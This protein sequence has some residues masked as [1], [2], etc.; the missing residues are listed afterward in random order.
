MK[1]IEELLRIYQSKLE[2]KEAQIQQLRAI[3][4]DTQAH[5]IV[6]KYYLE[7]GMYE[8]AK[9]YLN[10]ISNMT[11]Q[12][13]Y[14][15]KLDTGNGLVN[16][17]LEEYLQRNVEIEFLCKGSF[18]NHMC[19]SE[20]D[21]CILCS[22]LFSN[23]I[24]AVD[25]LCKMPKIIRLE[26]KEE[27][28][29]FLIILENYIEWEIDIQRLGNGTSKQDKENHGYG[30]KNIKGIVEKYHGETKFL[31]EENIFSVEIKLPIIENV[32]L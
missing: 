31:V 9:A 21:I 23:A 5:C 25:K 12:H 7:S 26:L 16:A 13:S 18:L 28:K 1:N 20:Y 6:L 3:K 22:N 24:E 14:E 11:V 19:M 32:K 2:E 29:M 8:E 10:E 27:N 30:L 4:H 17:L 15:K